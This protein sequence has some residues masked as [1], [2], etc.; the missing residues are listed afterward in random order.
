MPTTCVN[1]GPY[2][3]LLANRRSCRSTDNDNSMLLHDYAKY[4]SRQSDMLV[5]F[6]R[7]L[8]NPLRLVALSFN[9]PGKIQRYKCDTFN[10]ANNQIYDCYDSRSMKGLRNYLLFHQGNFV[11]KRSFSLK[12]N[13]C[14]ERLFCL[15]ARGAL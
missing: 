12:Q 7:K 13:I 6:T 15:S 10:Y 5:R 1:Q 11:F 4:C 3:I 8:I 2:E 9:T 14:D